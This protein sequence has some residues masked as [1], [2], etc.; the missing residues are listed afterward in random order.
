MLPNAKTIAEN[1]LELAKQIGSP[2]Q[3]ELAAKMG[4]SAKTLWTLKEGAGNPQLGNIEK[5]A[6]FFKR[7][8]WQLLVKDG[9]KLPRDFDPWTVPTH[10]VPAGHVRIEV[11]DAVPSAGPGGE[12]VDYP[13]VLGHIDVAEGWARKRLG[14]NLDGVRALPVAGDSMSPT[15]NE[16]DL[17][18]V[19]TRCTRFEAEGIYVIVFNNALLIKRL[20]ADLTTRRI[21]VKSDNEQ[22]KTQLVTE[23]D[24]TI[25]GRVKA[26]LAL[27]SS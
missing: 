16:G 12:P 9:H 11:L 27:R 6:A 22:H 2:T 15:I 3:P 1:I 18:F 5:A 24:L 25:C 8:T 13:A 23:D 26:W 14:H 4:M 10:E 7:P 17:A 20:S 19:D 21:E